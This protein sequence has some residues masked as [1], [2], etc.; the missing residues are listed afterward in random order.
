M[1]YV[2][3]V[4]TYT[5]ILKR[6]ECGYTLLQFRALSWCEL[7]FADQLFRASLLDTLKSM[8]TK[9]VS[10]PKAPPRTN[11]QGPRINFNVPDK[12]RRHWKIEAAKRDLTMADLVQAAMAEYLAKHP[13]A[14]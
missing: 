3:M 14:E 9:N 8:S 6:G 4:H 13:V 2:L 7:K 12:V 1:V 10:T 11:P 5:Q